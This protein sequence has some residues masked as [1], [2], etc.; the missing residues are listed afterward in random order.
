MYLKKV[1][2]R[3]FRRLKDISI[4]FEEKETVF[5]GPNNSGKTSA[6]AA[7]RSFLS[8][9]DFKVHDFSL[10]SLTAINAYDPDAPTIHP[11]IQ[12]D[13]WF[14][15]DPDA[16]EFGTVFALATDL[17][18]DFTEVG[19][20]CS[21]EAE[22]AGELW[23][24]YDQA[25]P[26]RAD[27][28][29]K[30]TL[31]DF[32]SLEGNLNAY[33]KTRYYSLNNSDTGIVPTPLDPGVGKKTLRSLLRV[34]FVDAQ[35]NIDDENASRSN[36]LSEAFAAY[37]QR[38][39]QKAEVAEGAVA[40]IEENNQ[41]LT[42]HYQQHFQPLMGIISEL[43]L[44]SHNDRAM[45]VVST[46]SS[47]VALRGSSELFY[48]DASSSHELPEA[49]NGLGFKN[50]VFMAVQID[51]FYKQWLTTEENRPLCQ[52]IFVEEPEVH[53]HAQV[54]QTFIKQMWKV[55]TQ[56][57]G[58]DKPLP[59]LTVTTHSSHVLDAVDFSKIRYFCRVDLDDGGSGNT[60]P[61]SI[62]RSLREFR[63]DEI[64]VGDINISSDEALA[65][66]KKYLRLTHCDLF[67]ADA[68]ILVE[69]A[70]E[71]LLLPKMIDL[72]ANGLNSKY[73]TI[74]EVGGAYSMRFSK[75][76]DF[77]GI[78]YL[79]ITDIDSVD[80]ADNRKGCKATDAG[81]VTSNAS[82]KYFFS[83][84]DLVSDLAT[85]A[86]VD[87]IQADNMRFVAYQKK[88][89]IEYEG[90]VHSFHGRTLEET[91]VYENHEL[92]SSE[93]LSIGKEIPA[94][95]AEFHDVVWG[96]IKSSTFKKTEFAMD[97]LAWESGVEGS[98]PWVVPKY[99]AD[100]LRWLESRVNDQLVAGE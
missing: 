9:R 16:I 81:A 48:V 90:A 62:V 88:L 78:P 33:F 3:N 52:V 91:F 18:G 89:E 37:Y 27:G 54:Q 12:L 32:L 72:S 98:A 87:H 7:I 15:I 100:G 22:D 96:R 74:L 20:R 53:L 84:S 77:L 58:D 79:I 29:R 86:N 36:K 26:V 35:R 60:Y 75:L 68:A 92:F 93:A 71:K 56:G 67:F 1:A 43:G 59:Q 21:L 17:T 10:C 38:N 94:D 69:G 82:I 73:L 31:V 5:V 41:N 76:I 39:L 23:T 95:A 97:V 30:K 50:L 85:K 63:P 40:V 34:D 24:K 46:L 42:D 61:G 47:E 57:A 11:C 64:N 83:D 4:D 8:N 28:Q 65:F 19:I 14:H 13:L 45:K 66:L 6:T 99:I 2:I 55:V 80:P 70:V 51:N 49:Y 25:F 44:P